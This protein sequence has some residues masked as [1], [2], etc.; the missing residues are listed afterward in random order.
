MLKAPRGPVLVRATVCQPR[1]LFTWSRTLRPPCLVSR[2]P[3]TGTLPPYRTFLRLNLA[4]SG[5]DAFAVAGAGAFAFAGAAA[6]EMPVT[7]IAA[8]PDASAPRPAPRVCAAVSN[9]MDSLSQP[10][11]RK[12]RRQCA[13]MR[14]TTGGPV[15]SPQAD[16]SASYTRAGGGPAVH[17]RYVESRWPGTGR[18]NNCS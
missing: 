15:D 3:A 13:P 4:C 7:V 2:T 5:C 11:L 6:L 12:R 17:R 8:A 1:P 10:C 18:S 16:P 9:C 14:A